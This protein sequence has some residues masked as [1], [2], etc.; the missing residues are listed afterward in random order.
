MYNCVFYKYFL[1]SRFY[2]SKY[3][4]IEQRR[5][6]FGKQNE[7]DTILSRRNVASMNA[8][9]SSLE[10]RLSTNEKLTSELKDSVTFI[11]EQYD[12]VLKTCKQ[13]K[14]SHNTM[15]TDIERT[16]SVNEELKR[17]VQ[18][19][20]SL[21]KSLREDL[22][23]LKCRSMRDNLIFSHIPEQFQSSNGRRFE[24]T[25]EVLSS[26]LRQHL[27]ISD[28]KF[29]RV[30]RIAPTQRSR[31]DTPRPIVAKFTLFK[32]REVV[33]CA[34]FKLKGTNFGISEQFP[35]EILVEDVRRGL[36]PIMRNLR[37]DGRRVHL[38]R[39]KLYVDGVQYQ[40]EDARRQTKRTQPQEQLST[41]L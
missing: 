36:Y 2:R 18:E 6:N 9:L 41:H 5:W 20:S 24:D 29:D 27:Q 21:N 17:S 40:A 13:T 14:S 25:E 33:R 32:E 15:K 19:L 39:D 37:R 12:S 22:I 30:H 23:D 16:Q 31:R 8:K 26:F 34:A 10:T 3:W 11:S 7:N 4:D 38:V 28:V 1:I 35:E